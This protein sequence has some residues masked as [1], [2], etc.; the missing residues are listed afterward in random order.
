MFRHRRINTPDL[1]TRRAHA[2][3]HFRLLARAKGRPIAAYLIEGLNSHQSVAAAFGRFADRRIPFLITQSVIDRSVRKRFEAPPAD[4][5]DLWMLAQK[6]ES[7]IDPA[8][9]ED[10]IAIEELHGIAFGKSLLEL[11]VTGIAPSSGTKLSI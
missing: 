10:A 3:R 9:L 2:C 7:R 6:G 11:G 8:R 4:H 5:G 1:P